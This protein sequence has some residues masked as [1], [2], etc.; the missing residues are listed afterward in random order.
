MR[1]SLELLARLVGCVC[2]FGAHWLL[3]VP[4]LSLAAPAHADLPDTIARLKPSVVLVGTFKATNS[5][6]FQLRGTGF[7]VGRGGQVITNAHVL[8]DDLG[9]SDAAA[10][11]VQVR[12]RDG[13]WQMR[14][15]ELQGRS[16]EH[17]LALLRMDG[18][19]APAMAIGDSA[20]VRE[21]DS[22]AFMGF[23]IGGVLGFLGGDPPRHGVFH[24]R[25]GAAQPHRRQAQARKRFA[26][27]ATAPSASFSSTPP[28]TQATAAARCSIPIPA[29]W[30]AW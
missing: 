10:L 18:P 28:P 29:R 25:G 11:V 21:G 9:Q 15:A 5:P 26:A 17:D 30:W 7:V 23:P 8:P 19:A 1:L 2:R 14:A 13:A 4:L 22:L 6:R 3:L 24:H 16:D 27:C 20:R 12:G